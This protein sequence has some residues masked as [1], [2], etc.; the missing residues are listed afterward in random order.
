VNPLID[1]WARVVS[2]AGIEVETLVVIGAGDGSDAPSI[3]WRGLPTRQTVLVEGD[4]LRC[5]RLARSVAGAAGV[6]VRHLVAAA[7]AGEASWHRFEPTFLSGLHPQQDMKR[8]F[9]RLLLDRIETVRTTGIVDLLAS[10]LPPSDATPARHA[11]LVDLSRGSSELLAA[12]PPE[13][14]A[15]FGTVAVALC[16]EDGPLGTELLDLWREGPAA[17]VQQTLDEIDG[18]PLWQSVV[19]RRDERQAR[20]NHRRHQTQVWET[21]LKSRDQEIERLRQ[22]L[23]EQAAA[24]P[25][26]H[27]LSVLNRR[28]EELQLAAAAA[29]TDGERIQEARGADQAQARERESEL[30]LRIDKVRADLAKVEGEREDALT[31]LREASK[32]AESQTAEVT[33]LDE[34]LKL[35]NE[36]SQRLSQK[37]TE[38]DARMQ[39]VQEQVAHL[40]AERTRL[41]AEHEGELQ[42][43]QLR[44]GEVEQRHVELEAR[45]AEAVQHLAEARQRIDELQAQLERTAADHEA[46]LSQQREQF[47]QNEAVLQQKLRTA[48]RELESLRPEHEQLVSSLRAELDK[49]RSELQVLDAARQAHASGLDGL[50]RAHDDLLATAAA[51]HARLSE[52]A[53]A[54]RQA[55]AATRDELVGARD[56]AA[57]WKAA[58]EDAKASEAALRSDLDEWSRQGLTLR[59]ALDAA[60]GRV[61]ELQLSLADGQIQTTRLEQRLRSLQEE[62]HRA[63]GQL[64]LVK[65]LLLS[66]S[67]I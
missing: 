35:A 6:R 30:R 66:D 23:D 27:E 17:L 45:L 51:E 67:G 41:G 37:I 56:E 58:A 25:L 55:L 16:R 24:A 65:E 50:R 19:F 21:E 5:A 4:E 62:L 31:K 1:T 20:E 46:Q 18:S 28:I 8:L 57:R 22:A 13:M 36:R 63:E 29:V 49:S 54:S 10:S 11:L 2:D 42:A 52:D 32:L 12:V 47:A 53:L 14:L 64:E 44:I 34:A 38:R 33:R 60:N 7:A 43:R 9:P 61:Q 39:R 59:V 26:R 48:R 15:R 3:G 40:E